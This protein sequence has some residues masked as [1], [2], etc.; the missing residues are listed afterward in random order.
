MGFFKRLFGICQTQPPQ[1]PSCWRVTGDQVEVD[2]S[3][4]SELAEPNGAIRLEGPNLDKR[5]LVIR[6]ED[7][8]HHAYVNKCTHGGR[9]LDP[10]PGTNGLECCSVGKSRFSYDG[11]RI[12]GSAKDDLIPLAVTES[13]GKVTIALH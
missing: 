3:R 12:G 5:I 9:R 6:G 8:Q 11:K 4:A 7:G 13:E 1:D 2:L 10:L